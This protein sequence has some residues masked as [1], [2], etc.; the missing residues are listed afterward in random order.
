MGGAD[1]NNYLSLD[2]LLNLPP[3]SERDE[4]DVEGAGAAL[5]G[6]GCAEGKDNGSRAAF[7][8][9]ADDMLA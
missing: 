9:G 7:G 5:A 8:E 1:P 2:L 6:G 3:K 4:S